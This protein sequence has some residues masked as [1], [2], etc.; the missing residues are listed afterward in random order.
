MSIL[1]GKVQQI[2]KWNLKLVMRPRFMCDSEQP[3]EIS[4]N[5]LPFDHFEIDLTYDRTCLLTHRFTDCAP[6]I[7]N[8][9]LDDGQ[10][11]PEHELCLHLRG[12]DID[13]NFMIQGKTITL[14][15]ELDM[16]IEDIELSWYFNNYD[17]FFT[18]SQQCKKGTKFMSENGRLLVK[19]QT[20]I[21]TWL[22]ENEQH[23]VEQYSQNL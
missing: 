11:D 17:C 20:P 12:A 16:Y 21:Y 1:A 23:I 14:G 9:S 6:V 3:Q 7:F 2:P 15:I 8:A 19:L 22:L 10:Q 13:N 18:Q 4:T 5:N